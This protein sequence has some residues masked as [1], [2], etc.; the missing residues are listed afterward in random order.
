M[1]GQRYRVEPPLAKRQRLVDLKPADSNGTDW[2]NLGRLAEAGP[3]K[4]VRMDLSREHVL[5]IVGKRGS[6]KSFTLGSFLEGLCTTSP[7]TAISSIA[8]DRAALLFD[9]LNIFQ[10]MTAPVAG[11][12]R[13]TH[14]AEQARLL[15]RWDLDPVDLDVDLWVPAGYEDRVTGRAKPF[16]IRT[17]DMELDDWSSLLG[18]D[19]VQDPMGQLLSL[20][21][22]KV[23]RR[24]WTG[25]DGLDYPAVANYTIE[26]LVECVRE[27]A[28][29]N[30]DYARET[31]RALRQ[32]LAAYEASP[33][34][35]ND[36]TELTE[37]LQPGRLSVLLLSGVPDDVRL[38]SIF[39]TIRKLLFARAQAS[40]AGKTKELG[41]A[42]DDEESA[43]VDR[44]LAHAPPKTW[45]VIDEAQNIFPS[46]KKTAASAILLRFVRE[47]RN[48][49]LSLAF[50]TQQPSAIDARIMAQVDIQIAHTLT[51]SKD[52]ANVLGNL[53]AREPARVQLRGVQL[54]MPDAVRHLQIGQAFV[55]SVDAARSFFMDVRPR[56][57]VHGGYEG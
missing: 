39:L 34:F 40:E 56:T 27:D 31:L 54:S 46:E 6:G 3:T 1:A 9:T 30:V 33:L 10:W 52:I 20:V 44:I 16:R 57:S 37:L 36:G 26:D 55:S 32:R 28:E 12:A 22:D 25:Q 48:F 15:K 19:A 8:K 4:E 49:G 17:R 38:V 18:V 45:V 42:G 35:G 23:T 53:K 2:V 14:V 47:G 11:T 5:S 21:L 51:V 13:S 50:T 43:R 41:F 7:S 29:V 24:G